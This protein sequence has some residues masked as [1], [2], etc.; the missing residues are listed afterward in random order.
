LLE[1]SLNKTVWRNALSNKFN[2]YNY[3]TLGNGDAT[4][5]GIN[6]V[7]TLLAN[8]YIMNF[9]TFIDSWVFTTIKNDTSTVEDEAYV[10]K[11]IVKYVK[12]TRLGYHAMTV[13]GYND[14]IW[15]DING[16][17]VVDAGEKG[18]FRIANSWRTGYQD[19]GYVWM[20][21]DSLK[22][23]SS[24]AGA[25]LAN[26][27]IAWDPAEVG[28]TTAIVNY[29]PTLIAEFTVSHAK[30][31]QFRPLLGISDTSITS[32]TTTLNSY[33]LAYKGGTLNFKGQASAAINGTFVLDFTSLVPSDKIAR[34]YY[35]SLQ[36]SSADGLPLTWQDYKLIDLERNLELVSG[37]SPKSFESNT[38]IRYLTYAMNNNAPNINL[39]ASP[40]LGLVPLEV[41]FSA[42]GSYDSEG[43]ITSY[44][45][46]F[47]DG[48]SA[49]GISAVHIYE[50]A[51]LY[52]AV[53][54]V[55]DDKL[56]T[57][58]KT[59]QINPS[60]SLTAP[61]NVSVI[62]YS[63]TQ[64]K[65]SW[66]DNSENEDAFLIEKS[67][68]GTNFVF[69]GNVSKN[70]TSFIASG[71]TTGNRYYFRIQATN[72]TSKS[73]YSQITS[74]IL[75]TPAAP[76]NLIGW[77][78]SSKEFRINFTDNSNDELGFKTD[79]SL[80][81]A[82]FV[83]RTNFPANTP[84]YSYYGVNASTTYYVRV[85]AFNGVGN[86]NYSNVISVRT[87]DL[88]IT[89]GNL[90]ATAVSS[91]QIRLTW[92]DNSLD[93]TGFRIENSTNGV[94]FSPR[95]SIAANVASYNVTGLNANTSYYFRIYS[96]RASEV[97]TYSNIASATT[98]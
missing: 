75:S 54:S 98:L 2:G 45:W 67:S 59:I 3:L 22:K 89:P 44:S 1:W 70:I 62:P 19:G 95:A 36:E 53:L 17:N 68:D 82:N 46:D 27:T 85:Y 92:Q 15:T 91:N 84:T 11:N 78:V 35:I 51:G 69:A 57:S 38:S 77:T 12:N 71:L 48:T 86:S 79:Y 4:D 88:P 21:Y 14:N 74:T 93:E 73:S 76:S 87:L 94:N 65:I 37:D 56:A 25:N 81:G 23:S 58:I 60:I 97:S 26:K 13:V 33:A 41:S 80:D 49:T 43:N 47:G 40:T 64:A 9:P 18:A 5:A 16:N 34:N 63:S 29:T 50:T 8:G 90:V 83:Y 55:K 32:P 28:Y 31:S 7:K 39:T 20:S 61:I 10:G 52:K 6:Q 30:R 42:A 72:S 24:V 66:Q 96:Y